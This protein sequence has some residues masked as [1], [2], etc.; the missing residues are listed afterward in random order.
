[1]NAAE[2]EVRSVVQAD[3]EGLWNWR[4]DLETLSNSLSSDR[5]NWEDHCV[6]FEK[7]LND[8]NRHIFIGEAAGSEGPIGMVRFDLGDGGKTSEVSINLNP[9]WR[10][11][12]YSVPLLSKAIQIYAD[13]HH[14]VLTAQIKPAN[15]PSIKCFERCGFNVIER[16]DTVINLRNEE[17]S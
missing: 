1:M 8:N 6:W 12:G 10:G 2:I 9:A 13:I 5:V 4:N 17:L 3:S 11:R 14:C 15:I 7:S 16:D